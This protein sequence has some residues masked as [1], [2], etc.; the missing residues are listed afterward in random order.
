MAQVSVKKQVYMRVATFVLSFVCVA[1]SASANSDIPNSSDQQQESNDTVLAVVCKGGKYGVINSKGEVVVPFIYSEMR[2]YSEGLAYAKDNN[3]VYFIDRK[4]EK[5]LT[6][7]GYFGDLHD[8]MIKV[9]KGG[10]YGFMNLAG[11][12]VVPFKYDEADNFSE[13]MASVRIGD[14]CGFVDTSGK[15]VIPCIYDSFYKEGDM[16]WNWGLKMDFHEGL[17]IVKKGDYYGAVNKRGEVIVPIKYEQVNDFREGMAKVVENGKAGYVNNLGTLVIPTMYRNG[18]GK[19]KD[20]HE[21]LVSVVKSVGNTFVCE[22]KNKRGETVF[23]LP[24]GKFGFEF[25]EGIAVVGEIV[26]DGFV[27]SHGSMVTRIEYSSVSHF[28]EGL[29]R[30]TVM[31]ANFHEKS[32]FI[33]KSG[34]RVI[35]CQ[36]ADKP[37]DFHNGLAGVNVNGKWGFIDKNGKVVIPCVYDNIND[38]DIV[39][40]W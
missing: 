24:N 39:N 37:K 12:V 14:K 31:D 3:F 26:K 15:E 29:A 17:A 22:Y 2:N 30:V 21:G 19:L 6:C 23:S 1:F 25:H 34:T 40:K 16:F 20:F 7:R 18:N 28:S 8:G 11:K 35:P 13:G 38:F 32:G 10:K 27:N 9:S 33:D 5:I 4:G 36:F